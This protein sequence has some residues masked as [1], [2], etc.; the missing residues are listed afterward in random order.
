MSFDH[1]GA[2]R[3]RAEMIPCLLFSGGYPMEQTLTVRGRYVGRTF[4]PNGPLP[5]EEGES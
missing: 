2:S 1:R 3:V 5:D 4:I